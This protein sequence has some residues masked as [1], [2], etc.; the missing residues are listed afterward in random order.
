MANHD[1]LLKSVEKQADMEQAPMD[2]RHFQKMAEELNRP[3]PDGIAL[4]RQLPRPSHY[5]IQ[6]EETE[7]PVVTRTQVLPS[8]GPDK[9]WESLQTINLDAALLARNGVFTNP[10]QSPAAA[11][12]DILRTRTLQAMQDRGWHRIAVT[13]PTHDCGKSFVAANLAFSLARRPS[14]RTILVDLEMREPG[15]ANLLGIKNP[16][17]LG[18][19][20]T[21]ARPLE[22]R[23]FRYGSTLALGLNST[24]IEN[25]A[26]L[27]DE[28]NTDNALALMLDRLD[29]Q[30]AIYDA[31]PA[32]VSDDVL[33]LL[34]KV[35][36]VLL[37]V[38]GTRTTAEEVR[39]CER[40]FEGHC[41]L[42]GVVLNRAQDRDLGRYR[43][44]KKK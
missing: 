1:I 11:Y 10:A 30:I 5:Q 27:L 4:F 36:A 14:S 42:M 39:D 18:D 3:L 6:D 9:V 19:Y 24:S 41:P 43:Y 17:A 20:L 29:P 38:D 12:F 28:A 31:P 44:G 33:T 26:E 22:E 2:E 16:T 32:L 8:Q 15:L 13:S 40:L 21:G 25:A 7:H 23:F 37:V 35:D 34:P